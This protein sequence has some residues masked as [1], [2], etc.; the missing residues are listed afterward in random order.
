MDKEALKRGRVLIVEDD[1][2]IRELVRDQLSVADFTTDEVADGR[3]AL[4]RARA[5]E[6]QLII[7]DLMLPHLDVE[8]VFIAGQP[9]RGPRAKVTDWSRR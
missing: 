4:E 2:A 3:A 6:Y 8:T 9:A 1:A 7:L 5:E